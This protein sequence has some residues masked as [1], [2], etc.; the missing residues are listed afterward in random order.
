[1]RL[2]HE[3]ILIAL[4]FLLSIIIIIIIMIYDCDL[5]V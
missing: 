3:F 1:M 5:R 4:H 2:I